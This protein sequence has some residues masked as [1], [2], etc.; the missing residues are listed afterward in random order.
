M[1]KPKQLVEMQLLDYNI[2]LGASI[3]LPTLSIIKEYLCDAVGIPC[4]CKQDCSS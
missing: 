4:A 3:P 1:L 2:I